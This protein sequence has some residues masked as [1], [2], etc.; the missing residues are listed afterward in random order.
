MEKIKEDNF[1]TLEVNKNACEIIRQGFIENGIGLGKSA[2]PFKVLSAGLRAQ[3]SCNNK[4]D[5]SLFEDDL[6][7][8]YKFMLTALELMR[9]LKPSSTV[10]SVVNNIAISSVTQINIEDRISK[11]IGYRLDEQTIN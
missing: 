8:Q 2:D 6:N 4:F 5:A 3:K 9:V 1:L 11:I 10:E 7:T